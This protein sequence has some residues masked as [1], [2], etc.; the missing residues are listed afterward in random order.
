MHV[1]AKGTYVLVF[2]E[3]KRVGELLPRAIGYNAIDYYHVV[4]D[5]ERTG[6]VPVF[7]VKED[8]R[9]EKMTLGVIE[10]AVD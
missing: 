1:V 5:H 2:C 7:K 10:I 8:Q 3:H 6:K 9:T 4:L